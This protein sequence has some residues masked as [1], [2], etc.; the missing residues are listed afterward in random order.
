MEDKRIP[1][2]FTFLIASLSPIV[3]YSMFLMIPSG[4][5][6][7]EY[8]KRAIPPVIISL[9]VPVV[10]AYLM[11]DVPCIIG[12]CD[13]IVG[14]KKA[15]R[16]LEKCMRYAMTEGRLVMGISA[17]SA[18]IFFFL[19]LVKGGVVYQSI[20]SHLFIDIL[21]YYIILAF[22]YTIPLILAIFGA[23]S[24]TDFIDYVSNPIEWNEPL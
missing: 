8:I 23:T 10:V 18:S 2:P 12:Q 11:I 20:S 1:R 21:R 13:E 6:V 17:G 4:L 24:I 5:T 9:F 3:I 14:W 15:L 19:P 7:G 16:I 22:A